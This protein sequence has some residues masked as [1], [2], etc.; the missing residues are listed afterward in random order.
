MIAMV[1]QITR[2][3]I[4]YSTVYSGSDQ[5]KHQSSASLA[6][7]WGIYRWPV[8]SP[9]K[10]P[11]TRKMFPIDDVIM[12]HEIYG[13]RST[14]NYRLRPV[15]KFLGP[16]C[17]CHNETMSNWH[18]LLEYLGCR[19]LFA[20]DR[21]QKMGWLFFKRKLTLYRL[22]YPFTHV[23]TKIPNVVY[24]ICSIRTVLLWFITTRDSEIAILFSIMAASEEADILTLPIF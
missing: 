21:Q 24:F 13:V 16:H 9:H 11:V 3:T 4:V 22:K 18:R 15:W 17:S 19:K 7:E 23:M 1:Y 14:L 20:N 10:W 2:L 8:N 12:N 5:R 6:F